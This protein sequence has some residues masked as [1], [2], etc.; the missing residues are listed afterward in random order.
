MIPAVSTDHDGRIKNLYRVIDERAAHDQPP[1]LSVSIHH[2]V[3]RR[4]SVTDDLPRAEDLSNY[5]ICASGDLVLNRMRAFQGAIGISRER[6]L[7]SPDYLVLRPNR[8]VEA[9][10]L[11]HLFRSTWFVGEMVARL[12]GI[13]STEQ[14]NVRTPRINAE[15]LGDIRVA[16]P[17]LAEQ[18]RIAGFLDAETA[19]ID[20]LIALRIK[21]SEILRDRIAQVVDGVTAA[22]ADGLSGI[23][24]DASTEDWGVGK[25]SRLCEIVPGF[26]FPSSEFLTDGTGM[27]L[28]RGINVTP[29]AIS[30]REAVGWDIES[31][32]VPERFHLRA[33]DLVV[34][35]D[36]PWISEGMRISL[37]SEMD[38]PALLLQRVACLR[39]R[40]AI[41]MQYVYW[42]LNSIHFRLSI[43]SELT[44]VSVPHLSGEQIGSFTFR[45][46]PSNLQRE[47]SEAL[48]RE[49]KQTH[50][51]KETLAQQVSLLAERRAALITATVTGQIDVSTASG[52][53]IED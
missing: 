42:A 30:W 45:L 50:H 17:S 9:R 46:P 11:H 24:I 26:A 25:L 28:L 40:S 16:L 23:G 3:V 51:L 27:R 53:G 47:I 41:S 19:R 44:G 36:R 39:P 1:L 22:S 49:A 7:V 43:E 33:G 52:R 12:R 2:G 15:D 14:G 38:L 21:Q 37:I 6:G 8:D 5:K 29:G 18:Q 31:F 34:G 20:N 4:D 32:P 48:A 13:G 35:M 10:Y